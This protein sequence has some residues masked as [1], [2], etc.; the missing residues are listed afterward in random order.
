MAEA[1]S[2]YEHSYVSN[3][4]NMDEFCRAL[5]ENVRSH[6]QDGWEL[7]SENIVSDINA[8]ELSAMIS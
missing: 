8:K 6:T 2:T 1:Y 4:K 7:V 3:Y 5:D